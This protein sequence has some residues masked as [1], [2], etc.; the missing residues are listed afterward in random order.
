MHV[1]AHRQTPKL[2]CKMPGNMQRNVTQ[3]GCL[4][5]VA[6]GLLNQFFLL[7]WQVS[8]GEDTPGADAPLNPGPV[9]WANPGS[10]K[11]SRSFG[12][13]S[14]DAGDPHRNSGRS[15]DRG[16]GSKKPGGSFDEVTSSSDD[17][18]EMAAQLADALRGNQAWQRRQ[19]VQ[20]QRATPALE[21]KPKH[22][23]QK[24]VSKVKDTLSRTG[25]EGRVV[26]SQNTL[27]RWLESKH[28]DFVQ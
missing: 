12:E 8:D 6:A 17:P 4:H 10:R 9:K 2:S 26:I 23:R 19:F 16:T 18:E 28:H 24:P 1:L 21:H 7:W 3:S 22:S 15:Y 13:V 11:S 5:A 25:N 14:Q 20:M 27:L